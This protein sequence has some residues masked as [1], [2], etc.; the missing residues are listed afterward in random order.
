MRIVS[1]DFELLM[2]T[3]VRSSLWHGLSRAMFV[4]S[5]ECLTL[6]SGELT[7]IKSN[8]VDADC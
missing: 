7:G 5:V 1:Q 3:L 2:Y 6:L 8:S 4:E